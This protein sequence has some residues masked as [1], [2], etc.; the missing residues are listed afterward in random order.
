MNEKSGIDT[1]SRGAYLPE[2]LGSSKGGDLT[3]M[4]IFTDSPQEED[5]FNYT[6]VE[7]GP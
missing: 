7:L 4:R 2:P 3:E 6:N 1:Q 5:G